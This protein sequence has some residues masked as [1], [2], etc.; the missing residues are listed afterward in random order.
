M[1]QNIVEQNNIM[2]EFCKLT[3]VVL[4][5][6]EQQALKET[7]RLLS[8][9]CAAEDIAEIIIFLI[10]ADCPSAKTATEILSGN[11]LPMPIRFCIQ[12][13]P[14]LSPAV[15][16]LSQLVHSSHFLIIGSDLEMD[17]RVVPAMIETSKQHPD[18]IVCASKFQK[19]ARRENYGLIHFLCN[20]A[21]NTAVE[22]ILHIKGTELISTFQIYPLDLFR[23]MRFSNPKRTF[24]EY[25]IRPLSMGAN[26]IEIPTNYKRR[27]EGTS[28]FNPKRYIHLGVTFIRTAL[29]ERKRLKTKYAHNE[30]P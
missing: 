25:T 19:G 22:R 9:Y 8:V 11:P 4:A 12:Q 5:S 29:S 21:V 6:T 27:E 24:Y 16:E 14:G 26:Y 20:R 23:S 13:M 17:P 2:G 10:S 28:N 18:A 7:I 1:R 3:L 30:I 15:Y